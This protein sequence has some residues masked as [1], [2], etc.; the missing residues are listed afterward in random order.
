MPTARRSRWSSAR[1]S[2]SAPPA[3]SPASPGPSA[4]GQ[5]PTSSR[6]TASRSI[7]TQGQ[8]SSPALRRRPTRSAGSGVS[9]PRSTS[10]PAS[11][12]PLEPQPKPPPP[13]RPPRRCRRLTASRLGSTRTGRTTAEPE[14]ASVRGPSNASIRNPKSRQPL[15]EPMSCA[16]ASAAPLPGHTT[17]SHSR[18]GKTT[19]DG[20]PAIALESRRPARPMWPTHGLSVSCAPA[21]S[22]NS[23]SAACETL[24]NWKRPMRCDGRRSRRRSPPARRAM[25][26]PT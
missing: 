15:P 23:R 3:R 1:R 11:S 22:T 20:R 17:N 19:F 16:G 25:L 6:S 2:A 24:P 18:K 4:A 26:R 13:S 5:S 10:K 12:T 7:P 14:A 21:W 8:Q 9:N